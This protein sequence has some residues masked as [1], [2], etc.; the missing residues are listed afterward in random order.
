MSLGV[1]IKVRP[2]G[3]KTKKI[4]SAIKKYCVPTTSP[5]PLAIKGGEGCFIQDMDNNWFLDLNANVCSTPLGYNH[6]AVMEVL[7][8]YSRCTAHKVA[9]QDFYAEE[10]AELA[11]ALVRITPSHLKKV[12]LSNTGAEA[13][14]NA[15]KFAYRKL[16]PLAGVSCYGAFHGRTLGALTFTC[17]KPVQKKNYPQLKARRIKFCTRDSDPD[18]GQVDKALEAGKAAFIITEVVQGEGGYRIAGKRFLKGLEKAARS[19][20]VP[21]ILDE[22]QSG[23]GR[24]GTWWAFQ[25]YGIRPDIITSAKALQVGATIS[26][27]SWAVKE[28]GAVSSTWGGGARIDLAV[29]LATIQAIQKEKLM[30]NARKMGKYFLKLLK[31]AETRNSQITN[32]DGLGLML[33]ME[34]KTVKERD[35]VL[36]EAFRSGLILL[37]CGKKTIRFSPPLIIRQNEIDLGMG[38]LDKIL[39]NKHKL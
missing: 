10:H 4:D 9:G 39:K 12:F 31:E 35:R 6:P 27:E 36:Q 5:Y 24:T 30:A 17:S 2:P 25:H 21:L 28:A 22:I 19:A 3:P 15:L 13:V 7:R 26:S 1:K 32:V 11:K 16:G 20:G 38:I 8:R 18:I 33:R 34:F 29:G 37:P 23:L 14:E